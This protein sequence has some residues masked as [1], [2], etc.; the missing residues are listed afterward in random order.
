MLKKKNE[1]PPNYQFITDYLPLTGHKPV[2]CY[3]GTI[4]NPHNIDIPEDLEWHEMVHS[5]QQGTKPDVWWI[6]YCT[7][8]EFRLEQELE[9]YAR[10]WLFVKKHIPKAT[11]ESLQD[12]ACVLSSS[13]YNLGI[14]R[15]EAET[16]IRLKA[17][18]YG[19][20]KE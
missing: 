1:F 15:F 8:V 19:E 20:E 9:A 7:D 13:L 4:F 12:F 6:R 11:K 18:H 16:L 17:K 10:Q 2:F 5:R 14:N 3:G